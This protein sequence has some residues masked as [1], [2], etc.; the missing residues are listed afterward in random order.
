[1][2]GL[3]QN[4]CHI[5]W[6][7]GGPGNGLLRDLPR[8]IQWR[9]PFRRMWRSAGQEPVQHRA[10]RIDVGRCG[11]LAAAHLL[12]AGV[13]RG[14]YARGDLSLR[15]GIEHF[16]DPKIQQLR[17]AVF[18][19]QNIAGLQITMDN[20]APVR[21]LNRRRNL[22]EKAEPGSQVETLLIAV[23]VDLLSWHEL[24][25]E[26]RKTGRHLAS[27]QKAGDVGMIQARQDLA[28]L[29]KSRAQ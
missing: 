14:H 25:N 7:I 22:Q 3:L 10:Q 11:D 28:F 13:L 21:V 18:A 19:D 23:I 9:Q 27:V 15:S 12:R 2:K 26:I 16:R 8:S 6:D 17:R 4:R 5:H 20:E 29:L 24:H 1:M